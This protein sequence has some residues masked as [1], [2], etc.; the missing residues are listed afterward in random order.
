VFVPE[1][2]LVIYEPIITD[3]RWWWNNKYNSV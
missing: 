2:W 3:S 1:K